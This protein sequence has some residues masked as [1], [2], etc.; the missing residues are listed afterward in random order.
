MT[1]R[2]LIVAALILGIVSLACGVSAAPTAIPS[3]TPPPVP[4][5]TATAAP[6]SS[7]LNVFPAAAGTSWTY[8][9]VIDD[10]A[11]AWE[12][13]ITATISQTAAEGAHPIFQVDW[14]GDPAS[15]VQ[16]QSARYLVPLDAALF[17]VDSEETARTLIQA[18][19]A[20]FETS[21]ILTWPVTA[22][23][24]WGDPA[25]LA[26]PD[27]AGTYVWVVTELLP[28]VQVPAGTF[29]DCAVLAFV[30]N[31]DRTFRTFCPGVGF[32]RI[33]YVHHG[34]LHTETWELTSYQAGSS[35]E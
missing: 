28:E 8:H 26:Q 30:T 10:Q 15:W 23:Q 18:G 31:P 25:V 7:I 2:T 16:P 21:Q 12:G 24:M 6:G 27:N 13:E 14:T 32:V 33:E 34:S 5:G 35:P 19:G 11:A 17:E 20:G 3:P 9:A 29:R 4:A 22:G 1:S